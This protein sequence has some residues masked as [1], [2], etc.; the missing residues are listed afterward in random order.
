MA[1]GRGALPGDRGKRAGARGGLLRRAPSW[2]DWKRRSRPPRLAAGSTKPSVFGFLSVRCPR[3][4][5]EDVFAGANLCAVEATNGAF[6]VMQFRD[7]ALQ[8]DGSWHL[9]GLLRGQAGSEGEAALGA[10]IG[11]R[12]VLMSPAVTQASFPTDLRGIEFTWSAGP[13]GELAGSSTFTERTQTI[14]ARGLKPLSPVH[15]RAR[16]EGNESSPLLD[17][18]HPAGRG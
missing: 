7:V 14:D 13:D 17:P 1:R 4:K 12:F 11:A 16:R 8:G 15:L 9:S 10:A 5:R 6:E 3:A 2:G 18:P